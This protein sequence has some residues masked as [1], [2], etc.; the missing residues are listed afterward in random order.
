LAA[1][2]IHY[3]GKIKTSG[4]QG[5]LTPPIPRK[6][7]SPAPKSFELLSPVCL[8]DNR[9]CGGCGGRGRGWHRLGEAHD[10]SPAF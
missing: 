7:I 2:I 9:I 10:N 6:A 3:G 4:G 8:E 1:L 5:A